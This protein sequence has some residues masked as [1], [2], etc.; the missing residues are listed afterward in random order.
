MKR[1]IS[2]WCLLA[3]L[4]PAAAS[5]QG[6]SITAAETLSLDAALR[7]AVDQN[8]QVAS[9]N[10]QVEKAEANL[11]VARTR[12]LPVFETQVSAS[13]LLSP[14]EFAFPRGAF[15]DFPGTGP[16][17]DNDTTIKVP[18]RPT[19]YTS[20]QVSQ[21][22][23]QLFQIG[24][25]IRSAVAA[26]DIERERT[27]AQRLSVINDVKRLYFAILQTQSS[28]TANQEALTLY[29]ELDRVLQVRV[30]QQVAL[31]SDGLD[32]QFKLAQEELTRTTLQNA[33]AS[34]KE[35]LNQLL[36]RDVNTA[37]E[38]EDAGAL[39][40]LEVDVQAG[41]TH[42]LDTRPDVK[43]ARLKLEQAE[44]DRRI[45]HAERIPD[46]SLAVGYSS[47]FNMSVM[48]TNL[49][50]VGVQVKWEPFDWGRRS[51]ELAAKSHTITQAR[52]AVRDAEDRTV[53]EVNSLFRT[54]AEKKALLRVVETAQTAARE[55][56]R[57]KTNQYRIEAALLTDVLNV[58]AELADADDR[59]QQ[60]LLAYWTAK[61]DYDL[62]T[63]EEGLK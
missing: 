9:S 29:R 10:L 37:F 16:I 35:H 27:R 4:L 62:A 45:T 40:L 22:L 13:Q 18:K 21:P 8:R 19:Y 2:V 60:A 17:P 55:K 7:L 41:R 38:V 14:V 61:A 42:A 11:A 12:R 3:G 15:G 20:S 49:A 54:L 44:I 47:Y 43:E 36:G 34:Q 24:L 52:M 31:R 59:Y 57:V 26:R 63:G 39:S 25:G 30:T 32:V 33:L 56:V 5:A 1:R 53:L 46:V 28:M 23:S 6:G 50:T 48:P 58:R 51:R